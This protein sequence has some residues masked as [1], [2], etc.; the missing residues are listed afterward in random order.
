MSSFWNLFCCLG[1]FVVSRQWVV[2]CLQFYMHLRLT[3]LLQYYKESKKK[4]PKH[5][6]PQPPHQATKT[7]TLRQL[8][9]QQTWKDFLHTILQQHLVSYIDILVWPAS[10]LHIKWS[11]QSLKRIIYTVTHDK[12]RQS[13]QYS[14]L[15]SSFFHQSPNFLKP[16]GRWSEP[17]RL[18]I[19]NSLTQKQREIIIQIWNKGGKN[20]WDIYCSLWL[21]RQSEKSITHFSKHIINLAQGNIL[22][23]YKVTCSFNMIQPHFILPW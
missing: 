14:V 16:L 7:T 5:H 6:N 12:I 21:W 2:N 22:I 20:Y 9:S 18:A 1:F 10:L 3:M 4:K 23:Q 11:L 17:P 15:L 19:T 8:K 13:S